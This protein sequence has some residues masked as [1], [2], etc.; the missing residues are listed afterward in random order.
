[1]LPLPNLDDRL[2]DQMVQEARKAIPKLF[3]EWTDENA[4]DPGMT[5]LE[6][7]AWM[8]EMQQ[9]FLNRVTARNERKFLKL[10]GMKTRDEL[11]AACE[12]A[13]TGAAGPVTIPRGTPLQAYD[14]TFETDETLQLVPAALEK[15]IVRTETAVG[16]FTANL[17]SG[18]P[19]YAFGPDAGDGSRLFIGFDRELPVHTD[20]SLSIRLSDHYP[21]PV[22]RGGTSQEELALVASSVVSWSYASSEDG[23]GWSRVELLRDTTAHL[24]QSGKLTFRLTERMKPFAMYPA[25]DRKRYWLCGTLERGS[26][27]LSPKL[28]HLYINAVRAEHR[29][30]IGECVS[31]EATGEA[32][33]VCETVGYLP[34]FGHISVQ[35]GSR[36]GGWREWTIVPALASC[37]PG[38]ACCEAEREPS[39]HKVR[40][41]FGDGLHGAMPAKGSQIRL[42]AYAP[43]KEGL[44]WVGAGNGLPEQ[45]F[46]L[47]RTGPFRGIG[48]LLQAA[49]RDKSTGEW[50]W[51]DWE[52]VD[53]FDQSR[54]SDR[55]FVYDR[56][57]GLIRFGNNEQGRIPPKSREPNIRFVSLQTGGGARGNIKQGM[58][59]G[60]AEDVPEWAGVVASNPV[61]ATGGAE[62]ESLEEAKLRVQRE[63]AA[64][65]RAVTAEDYEA[66]ARDTP[67]L[68]VAR[69]KAIPLY[70]PGMR[71]YPREKAP[72]QMTVAVVPYSERDRPDAGPGFLETVSRHLDRHRLLGTEI[73]VISAAY[74]KITVHAVVVM[75]PAYKEEATPIVA[76]LRRLLR[77]MGHGDGEGWPFGRT[78]Y[79]GDIYGAISRLKGVVYVQDLWIDAEGPAV[80]K[81]GAGDI[82]LPPY[83]LVYSGDHEMEL[84]GVTD[85]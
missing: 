40:L 82:H 33:L 72:A 37:G 85:L 77:P 69:V 12:V 18:I 26:Y 76:V 39:A 70:K 20:I 15:L 11:P 84:I 65:T 42:V 24:S 47:S 14:Q 55:H 63:L 45:E 23:D 57:E 58:I 78:V 80:R 53:D 6:L 71:D 73:H 54:P 79:K 17:Q 67:G 56:A 31:F 4:H 19:F 51:E 16:D 5:M 50:V 3:P 34:Y 9:Y 52:R 75:E 62:T 68:R 2:Y 61:A 36:S 30:T 41:R 83:G 81:D 28:T 74:I 29:Q 43:A 21:V 64:P 7:M 48:M 13:F 35:V 25:D 27:E 32:G 46:D 49:Y 8:T 1:M 44:L 66:I 60:F 22:G 10:L 38:D 59:A